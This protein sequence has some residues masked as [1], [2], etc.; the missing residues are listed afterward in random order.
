M[1]YFV[2]QAALS[3]KADVS[4]RGCLEIIQLND[5]GVRTNMV[6]FEEQIKKL[7]LDIIMIQE[8]KLRALD[9]NPAINGY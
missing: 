9:K 3:R 7:N 5:D 6:E 8:M 4:R 2:R 1:L